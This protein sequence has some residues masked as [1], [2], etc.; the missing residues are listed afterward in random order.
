MSNLYSIVTGNSNSG[1]A[2]IDYLMKNKISNIEVRAVF[3]TEEK[4]KPFREKYPGLE[5]VCGVNAAEPETTTK[6]FEGANAAFIVTVYDHS[7]GFED[8]A[9]LTQ[10]LIDSAVDCGVEYIVL[11]ASFTVKDCQKMEII[12][13]RCFYFI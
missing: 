1:S 13:A 5:I 7:K 11:V 12:S 6:A 4:S 2:C 9:K 10:V 8:D 3:R